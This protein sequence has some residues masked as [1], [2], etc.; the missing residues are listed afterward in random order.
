MVFNLIKFWSIKFHQPV[1]CCLFQI[2]VRYWVQAQ[3]VPTT[4]MTV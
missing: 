4:Q 3:G 1:T 2:T